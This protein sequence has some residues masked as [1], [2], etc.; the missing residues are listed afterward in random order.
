MWKLMQPE[1][2]YFAAL[3]AV[4][5]LYYLLKPR[6]DKV[7]T[8]LKF[9]GPDSI[10]KKESKRAKWNFRFLFVS[11]VLGLMGLTY[12]AARPVRMKSWNKKI[13]DGIDIVVVLD[14][15]ESMDATDLQPTRIIAAKSVIHDFV[16]RRPDDRI[17]LVI[18]GGEAI[19]K[20]PLTRDFDF[21]LSQLEDVRL[22]ELKQGTAIGMGLANGIARLKR[23]ETKNKVMILLTD[24]DSNVG[25]INPV[26]AAHLARQEG[27][28]VY[29]IGIGKEDRVVVPIFAY[30]ASGRK[31]QLIAQVPSYINP[32]LLEEISNITGG[33]S[34]MARD[35]GM[36]NRIL[37]EIDK[38]EKTKI[39]TLPMSEREEMFF[40]PALVLTLIFGFLFYLMETRFR[41]GRRK[42]I[43]AAA[44]KAAA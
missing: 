5:A 26:T 21:L 43:E 8:L 38:L 23:S 31:T 3:P 28:R 44:G 16:N 39:K 29:T 17:G 14:V 24:G 32:K 33:K 10:L 1:A 2:L 4:F 35:S 41:K 30:D 36:L 6:S 13:T 11:F 37:I 34:Y 15:S 25:A 42:I 20:C 12:I 19:L 27:I 18:F 22:R 9:S 40:A 7:Q